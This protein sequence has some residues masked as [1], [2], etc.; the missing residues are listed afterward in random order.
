MPPTPLSH[1]SYQYTSYQSDP[2]SPPVSGEMV[3]DSQW[4]VTWVGAVERK[5]ADEGRG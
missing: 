5:G 1:T 4:R 3:E 2:H